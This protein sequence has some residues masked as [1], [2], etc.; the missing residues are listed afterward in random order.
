MMARLTVRPGPLASLLALLCLSM[1]LGACS[2]TQS[3]LATHTDEESARPA[4]SRDPLEILFIGSSYFAFNDLPGLFGSLAADR[5]RDVDI[6]VRVPLGWSL[7]D[8]MNSYDT[9][10]MITSRD[11]DIIILQG[12]GVAVAYPPW[13]PYNPTSTLI[14]FDQFIHGHCSTTEIM[15]SMPWAHEDGNLWHSGGTDDYFAMY[16]RVY[17]NTLAYPEI[18]DLVIA[19]VASAWHTIMLEEPP[20]HYLFA[21]DWYHPSQRGSYLTAC[22]IYASVFRETAVGADF[23]GGLPENEARHFQIVASGTVLNDLE[24]W[25]LASPVTSVD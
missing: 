7:N 11:W 25:H 1:C 15:F 8:H 5:G 19:P 9:H 20:L 13:V 18:V 3:P 12:S 17:D 16:E 2:E 10:E 14:W 24:L 22:A 4:P 21:D 6:E 23:L